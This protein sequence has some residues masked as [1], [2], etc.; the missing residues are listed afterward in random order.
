VKLKVV[1]KKGIR[2]IDMVCRGGSV[3]SLY[4]ALRSSGRFWL[5]A[6]KREWCVGVRLTRRVGEDETESG[7]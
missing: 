4:S 6:H 7:L 5:R 3:K 2:P 1:Y